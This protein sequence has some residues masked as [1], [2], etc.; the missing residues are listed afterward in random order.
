MQS[1]T[2][3]GGAGGLDP[4][5]KTQKYRVSKQYWLDPLKNHKNIG[6]Q[7]NTGLDPLK[8]HKANYSAFNV[9]PPSVCQRNAI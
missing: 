2:D 1:W 4:P 5:E 8:N 7:I 9:G 3:P 6:F